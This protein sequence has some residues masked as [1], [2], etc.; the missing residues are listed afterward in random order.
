MWSL[1][2]K[3]EFPSL[4]GH[5]GALATVNP[6]EE[7]KVTTQVDVLAVD[8]DVALAIEC[9]SS[10]A[11]ARRANFQQELAKHSASRASL[12][13]AVNPSGAAK[14]KRAI[15]LVMWNEKRVAFH[16]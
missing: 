10:E 7:R 14:D 5:G 8:E 16:E 11:R 12:S 6:G 13:R 9:K 3:M 2:W 1:L 4:C 15:V